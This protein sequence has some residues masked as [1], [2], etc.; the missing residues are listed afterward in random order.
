MVIQTLYRKLHDGVLLH[1]LSK[2]EAHEI[3]KETHDG[4]CG[5]HQTGSKHWDHL[6]KLSYFLSKMILDAMTFVKRYHAC[7]MHE[8]FIHQSTEYLYSSTASWPFELRV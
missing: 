1:Y 3:F 5:A 4:I 2:R 7:Q 8:N 6:R